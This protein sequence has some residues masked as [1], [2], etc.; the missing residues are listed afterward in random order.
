[1]FSSIKT[2]A[3][4]DIRGGDDKMTNHPNRSNK[5]SVFI[6]EKRNG[7]GG[8]TQAIRA[9]D[10]N[11][12]LRIFAF[13]V[14]NTKNACIRH[15]GGSSYTLFGPVSAGGHNLGRFQCTQAR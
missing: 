1:M 6:C 14:T 4:R 9:R 13:R 12:A 3:S 7:F 5:T 11:H 2:G 8:T 15:D 10:L